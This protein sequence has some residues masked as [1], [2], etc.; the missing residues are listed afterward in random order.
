MAR[1]TRSDQPP[2]ERLPRVLLWRWRRNPL[3]RRTDLAQAWIALGL[4]LAVLT[5]APAVLFLAGD[6]A[7]RHHRQAAQ[8]QAAHRHHTT[9][10]LV[11]DAPRHPEPGS[12]EAKRAL[13]PVTVRFSDP[14]GEIR[15]DEAE[16]EASLPAG[17]TIRVWITAEGE[18]TDPPLTQDQ[19]RNRTVVH[20]VLA[21]LTVPLL[22]AAAYGYAGRRLERRNLARW[23]TA[24]ARTAPR[25]TS[26]T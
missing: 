10:A 26:P 25:W 7:H 12:E 24:W 14:R 11:H 5:A 9:A 3:R 21:A 16:V 18:I 22:A 19:I 23:D 8:H 1:T 4:F 6:A 15:T 17:S 13:Y 20:A 2:P